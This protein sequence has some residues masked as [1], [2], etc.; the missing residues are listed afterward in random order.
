M[1]KHEDGRFDQDIRK[2]AKEAMDDA[3]RR[4][5][6]AA[7]EPDPETEKRL[8][9]LEAEKSDPDALLLGAMENV[10]ELIR[11][12]VSE[13]ENWG[14]STEQMIEIN[15]SVAE[16]ANTAMAMHGR[17]AEGKTIEKLRFMRSVEEQNDENIRK[18]SDQQ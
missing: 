3:M 8:E 9:A 18:W 6:A 15:R 10:C 13:A 4:R 17:I 2:M 12:N 11:F 14:M 1:E 5:A 7:Q 16:L